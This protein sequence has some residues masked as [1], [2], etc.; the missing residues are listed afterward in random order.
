MSAYRCF[1]NCPVKPAQ[2]DTGPS[3]SACH[4]GAKGTMFYGVRGISAGLSQAVSV[5]LPLSP[6]T[7]C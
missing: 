2:S 7:L 6:Q 3:R 4:D 5:S 1:E